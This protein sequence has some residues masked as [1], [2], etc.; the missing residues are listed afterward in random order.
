MAVVIGEV[1]VEER[2]PRTRSGEAA[3]GGGDAAPPKED[4]Q[5][6]LKREAARRARVRAT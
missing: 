6:K 3:S 1:V 2:A 4:V 5:I